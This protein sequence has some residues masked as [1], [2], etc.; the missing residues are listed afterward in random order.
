MYICFIVNYS[1][2]HPLSKHF[3][4]ITCTCAWYYI[5]IIVHVLICI[6]LCS[7]VNL[8][9]SSLCMYYVVNL[10]MIIKCNTYTYSHHY[11][12]ILLHSFVHIF[13]LF[14]HSFIH[15]THCLDSSDSC[16]A[17]TPAAFPLK[18][19]QA[20]RKSMTQPKSR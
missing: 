7:S 20:K 8:F 4:I 15:S 5:V 16:E 11:I 17:P 9:M 14:P 18:P 2:A 3:M 1:S 13:I 19:L 12:C 10:F 6:Q